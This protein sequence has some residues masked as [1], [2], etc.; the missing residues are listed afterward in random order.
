MVEF[1]SNKQVVRYGAP[2]RTELERYFV[3]DDVD[4]EAVQAKRRAYNRLTGAVGLTS[5]R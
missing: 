4:R 2:S 5:V 1:L 3:L